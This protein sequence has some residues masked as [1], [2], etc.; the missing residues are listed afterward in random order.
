MAAGYPTFLPPGARSSPSPI[1]PPYI[2]PPTN[3]TEPPVPMWQPPATSGGSSGGG[4]FPVGYGGTQGGV[5]T[6]VG[7]GWGGG[8]PI[9]GPGWQAQVGAA[10][11]ASQS[12]GQAMSQLAQGQYMNSPFGN[13]LMGQMSGGLGMDPKALEVQR[14]MAAE[15]EA[16][17]RENALLRMGQSAN[18]KGF[19]GSMGLV[20]AEGRLRADSAAN[21][22]NTYD[23]LFVQQEL[24][25]QRQKE[26]SAQLYA[27]L[28]GLEAGQS[29]MAAQLLAN[30]Q[31]PAIPGYGPGGQ[32]GGGTG[33]QGGSWWNQ[34]GQYQSG[35]RPY[36]PFYQP[37][38][39]GTGG[40]GYTPQAPWQP[41]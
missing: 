14:R 4:S 34:S 33:G 22:Q 29:G 26:A 31:F 23:Q 32:Q 25:K 37:P 30:R 6:P 1:P 11:Q 41:W 36:D 24:M 5:G 8:M 18:A 28:M 7:G 16:G 9:G 2:A 12:F 19:G 3:P 35:P 13:M 40:Q 38:T 27:Q 15:T 39:T 17:S 20:D 21:L 10:N